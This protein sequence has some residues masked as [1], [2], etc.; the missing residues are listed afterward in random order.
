[1]CVAVLNQLDWGS[2]NYLAAA[3]NNSVY[4]YAIG[5]IPTELTTIAGGYCSAVKW[6]SIGYKLII[7]SNIS[8]IQ[9]RILLQWKSAAIKEIV[10]GFILQ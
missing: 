2:S 1:M 7:G 8:D 4:L 9:V 5:E 10:F 6:D 3:L